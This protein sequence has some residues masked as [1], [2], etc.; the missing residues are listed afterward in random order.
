MVYIV[1]IVICCFIFYKIVVTWWLF[2]ELA[3]LGFGHL[4]SAVG[5]EYVE[6][7]RLLAHA[8]Q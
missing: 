4:E 2:F 8:G 1:F 6:G 5:L 3:Q 7:I